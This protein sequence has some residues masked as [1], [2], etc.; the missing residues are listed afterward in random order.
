[1]KITAA[2][3]DAILRA[4]LVKFEQG[5]VKA[6]KVPLTQ[7]QFDALVSFTFNLG[8][9]SLGKSM[10]LHKL[11][12]GDYTGAA[13]EFPKWNKS[14]GKVLAGLT[15]RRA[16]E[17]ALFLSSRSGRVVMPKNPPAVPEQTVGQNLT[18]T[19]IIVALIVAAIAIL[20]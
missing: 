15:R 6:V 5:V 11:N 8:P 10:L 14:N 17:Q 9:G 20:S 7:S 18:A 19:A 2:G 3:A 1:M 12:A 16:D 13:A 4:D